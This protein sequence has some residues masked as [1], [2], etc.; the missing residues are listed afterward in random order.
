MITSMP[1]KYEQTRRAEQQEETRRRIVSAAVELHGTEGPARTTMSAIAERAGVQ[2][3]TLYRHFPDERSILS[4]C[5]AH[6]LTEHPM[7]VPEEWA[8][9]KDPHQRLRRGL[10]ELYAYWASTE[11]MT[12]HVV[13]DAE[14]NP[15]VDEVL[16]RTS[17][18]PLA[19]IR[20]VLLDA[21]PPK[22]HTPELEAAVDLALNFRTWQSLTHGRLSPAA[23]ADLVTR[24]VCC[25]QPSV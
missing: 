4:A 20:T 8:S 12:A 6:F 1:R 19:A 18:P 7:P 10:A 17:G 25:C 11:Q 24:M 14:V 15:L 23:A 5:S 21:W 3:N 16:T 13:R 2:R 22:R 9:I